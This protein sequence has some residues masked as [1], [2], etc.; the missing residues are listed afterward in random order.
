VGAGVSGLAAARAL[1][2]HG[3]RVR[4]LE[5]RQRVG[6]RMH[7]R[8]GIDL[9]AHWIHGTEGNPVSN[10]ARRLGLATLYVGGD[11]TYTGGFDQARLF[12]D[13][14]REAEPR[15][16]LRSVLLA[17][18]VR[19]RLDDW[20][21]RRLS[22]AREDV[23][24][25]D[26]FE[27]LVAEFPDWSD[28]D[29]RLVGWH[30]GLLVRDDC[31]ADGHALSGLWWDEGYEVYGYGDSV[32]LDGFEAVARCLSADLDVRLGC[33]VRRVI[34]DGSS[35]RVETSLGEFSAQ[36]ALVTL[37]LGVLKA[38]D[39]AFEPPLGAR[40][41]Q[42]IER[43]GFGNLAKVALFFER[44]FWPLEQY[45]FGLV[46]GAGQRPLQVL[47]LWK[48]HRLPCLVVIVGGLLGK[49]IEEG[50]EDE[51]RRLALEALRAAFGREIPEPVRVLKTGWSAD[52]FARG[53]YAHVPVG[54]T[55]DDLAAMA[56]PEG[57][58]L[59]FAGEA[60]SQ[61]HWGSAHGAYLSG[62][63]EAARLLGDPSIVPAR[64]FAESRRWRAMMMR[65]ARLFE[66]REDAVGK[67]EV[68]D[69]A[70]LLA[71]CDV[72]REI[73]PAELHALATLFERVRVPVGHV[74][75]RAGEKADRVFV[76]CEGDVVI[77]AP[78]SA[79]LAAIG[80]GGLIGEF[81]MFKEE[82]RTATATAL[83]ESTLL[84]LDY[85]LFRRFLLVYPEAALA[86]LRVVVTRLTA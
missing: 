75:C 17:D 54:A 59:F 13:H 4:V 50:S 18:E 42:A 26:V 82:R 51:A 53:A 33:V 19:E 14:G 16:K 71:Q 28:E 44:P 47:N 64:H 31:A 67:D 35:V 29:R 66:L 34:S 11:S 30:L 81:G 15:Q 60:T 83:G 3:V 24:I 45:V 25:G 55:P 23:P 46:P 6:G 78:D 86:L 56:E 80:R 27:G 63:R 8:D 7:T 70:R 21:R 37:P 12:F 52:P 85:M 77:Q 20:R 48:T 84:T 40:K 2:D 38:G 22:D 79:P 5:A 68:A 74:L 73:P 62:V 32:F 1:H 57:E 49:G 58:R 72:F 76:V 10:L 9:G 39:V 36:A 43:L 61:E 41:A 65:A 69:R